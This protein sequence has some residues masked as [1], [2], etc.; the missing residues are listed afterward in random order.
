M[1]VY[2]I[3]PKTTS[4]ANSLKNL[5]PRKLTR[6][7][8][9]LQVA[10]VVKVWQ[11]DP[12]YQEIKSYLEDSDKI[13]QYAT[14]SNITGA[15]VVDIPDDAIEQVRKELESYAFI[16]SNEP[17][18]LIE[19]NINKASAKNT[20]SEDDLWHLESISLNLAR[21]NRFIGTG[22]NITVAVLD[23][24]VEAK[25]TEIEGKIVES[26]RLDSIS[27]SSNP[28]IEDTRY[29]DTQGH[30]THV[31]GL[32][33]GKTV[34]VAPETK[35]ISGQLIP[36]GSGTKADLILWLD[37][38]ATKPEVSIV[39][40]SAGMAEYNPEINDLINCI[41][42]IGM[43]PV[44]AIGNKINQPTNTPANCQ[45]SLSVGAIDSN[46]KVADFSASGKLVVDN[47]LYEVPYLVAPGQGIYSSVMGGGYEAWDG[48][49][50]ATPIVS[51]V[52]AL[53][54]EKYRNMTYD[55]LF[56]M[57]LDNCLLLNNAQRERQGKGL[58]QIPTALY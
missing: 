19:P 14:Y 49:S 53:I 10:E 16:S 52:A 23:T 15:K 48:T 43:L 27:N 50:M 9:V 37:W 41:V 34:G 44:C 51:G 18:D 58:V 24:G 3:R 21:Q 45:S 6:E 31:A 47:H 1:T 2:I 42:G 13:I 17:I 7:S 29:E 4:V 40:I 20:L 26:Y 5:A 56:N 35:I 36:G 55:A 28:I 46:R 38:L 30:G 57:L 39:N 32:I 25:H 54:L 22:K 8:R 33:C 11:E 12:V